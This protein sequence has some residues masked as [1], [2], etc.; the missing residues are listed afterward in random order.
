MRSRARAS[1]QRLGQP[2]L[3]ARPD[4]PVGSALRADLAASGRGDDPSSPAAAVGRPPVGT[5][6]R[7]AY[8]FNPACNHPC[9]KRGP[10]WGPLRGGALTC[11]GRY[12]VR[13]QSSCQGSCWG[14]HC[15][16]WT[17][18]CSFLFRGLELDF[19]GEGRAASGFGSVVQRVRK[20]RGS[21]RALVEVIVGCFE[22]GRS[23]HG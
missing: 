2:P 6:L 18:S 10:L 21:G 13:C 17:L 12:S 19:P 22:G 23:R 8:S 7:R 15:H 16:I 20:H 1:D 14:S 9:Q 5:Y 3:V 11:A 4:S